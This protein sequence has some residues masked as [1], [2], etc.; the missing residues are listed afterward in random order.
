MTAEQAAAWFL[1]QFK[2]V[3]AAELKLLS[4][5]CWEETLRDAKSDA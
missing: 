5:E 1:D 4:V 2:R 3:V